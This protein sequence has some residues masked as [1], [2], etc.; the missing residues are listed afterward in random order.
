MTDRG[1]LHHCLLGLGFSK[2]KVLLLVSLFCTIAS[3]GA[4]LSVTLNSEWMALLGAL[5]VATFLVGMRWFGHGE[6]N[7]VT[8]SLKGMATSM[9][10]LPKSPKARHSAVR[11]QG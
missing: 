1:H 6:L 11:I 5:G 9:V 10:T 3:L 2:V 7:L 4:Y 8:D